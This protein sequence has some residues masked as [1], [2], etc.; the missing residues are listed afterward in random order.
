MALG[1]PAIPTPNRV[2]LRAL[3]TAIANTRERIE[4]LEGALTALQGSTVQLQNTTSASASAAQLASLQSQI[5]ALAAR[6]TILENIT[7]EDELNDL[8]VTSGADLQGYVP[9]SVSGTAVLM[10]LADIVAHVGNLEFLITALPF[11]S[12][13][14]ANST[15]P[16]VFGGV[17]YQVTA[18]DLA[19]L[20]MTHSPFSSGAERDALVPVRL[21]NGHTV[22]VTTQD[23][24]NLSSGGSLQALIDALS[25]SSGAEASAE[26]PGTLG[27]TAY[28]Y[29]A[30]DI[31]NLL[32]TH[33]P[34]SSGAE[35]NALV[36]VRLANGQTVLVTAG[37]I[38]A[39][40][41]SGDLYTMIEALSASSGAE[42]NGDI[43]VAYGGVALRMR[44]Y[45]IANLL[46]SHS[47]AGTAAGSSLVPAL[48]VD[49]T[50]KLLTVSDI[51]ALA[52]GS[53]VKFN[54]GRLTLTTGS[55]VPSADVTSATTIYYTPYVGDLITLWTGTAWSTISF[56]EVS[57]ALGTMTASIGYDV[58]GFLNAGA[59]N[60]EKLAWTSATARATAIT[61]QDGRLC[62]TG[63][64]TRLW[65]GSFY[66]K[67]TTA[68]ADSGGG[69][70]T[71][72]GGQRFVYN[73]FNRVRRSAAVIDTTGSW[74]Y[75]LT[76]IRQANN[77]AGNKVEVFIGWTDEATDASVIGSVQCQASTSAGAGQG[78]GIDS[79]TVLS[80]RRSGVYAPTTN[81]VFSLGASYRGILAVGYHAINWLEYGVTNGG[82]T[83]FFGLFNS[84]QSGLDAMFAV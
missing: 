19:N 73:A 14:E 63:D 21:A 44:A 38:A 47:T 43:P 70:T 69:T 83:A 9:V 18:Y 49:A 31:A 41:G 3:Q 58:F 84:T 57:L 80:G 28:R 8:P 79:T 36:P 62:K 32:L 35:R 16:V 59:L 42:A 65:L 77:A 22:M 27:G 17:A 68:T 53:A 74:V 20:L 34:Y 50:T 78:I 56:S 12:G 48:Q 2:D 25:A 67:S 61:I 7:F 52:T 82:T 24:A 55:P 66:A 15:L 71:Q 30:F 6:V 1:K 60:I 26:I 54:Q 45:D 51:A 23:I 81:E 46:L 75:A 13:A 29:N 76:A 10:Q 39:L 4:A 64:K 33:P 40:A 72:V 37:D 5:T 11:M